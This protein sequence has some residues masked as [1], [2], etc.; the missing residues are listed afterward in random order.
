MRRALTLFATPPLRKPTSAATVRLTPG[1]VMGPVSSQTRRR[2]DPGTGRS[3]TL[4]A[5]E[6]LSKRIAQW[7]DDRPTIAQAARAL[8]GDGSGV[9]DTPANWVSVGAIGGFGKTSP[10]NPGFSCHGSGAEIIGPAGR[11]YQ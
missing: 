1:L 3:A 7:L 5:G 4:L 11:R 8:T 2:S 6:A 9:S 10:G